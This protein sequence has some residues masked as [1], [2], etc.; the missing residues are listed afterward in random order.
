MTTLPAKLQAVL[1]R[2]SPTPRGSTAVTAADVQPAR[3]QQDLARHCGTRAGRRRPA[4][5]WRK[6]CAGRLGKISELRALGLDWHFIGS[7]QAN[8]TRLVAEAFRLG[9][10]A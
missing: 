8:K 2:E 10:F 3:R 4:G 5:F 9:A 1:A 6:L 7:L